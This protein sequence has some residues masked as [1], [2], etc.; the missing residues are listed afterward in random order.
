MSTGVL[1][2]THRVEKAAA[3]NEK[4]GQRRALRFQPDLSVAM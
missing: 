4:A 1:H 3:G 2:E